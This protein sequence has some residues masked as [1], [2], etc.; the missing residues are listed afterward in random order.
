MKR[1]IIMLL[2]L[3][4]LI[5]LSAQKAS[6][7]RSDRKRMRQERDE[8][9]WKNL[10]EKFEVRIGWCGYPV[11]DESTL[12]YNQENIYGPRW[13]IPDGLEG[14]Y[15]IKKDN[16]YMTAPIFAEFSWHVKARFTLSG[17][18]YVNYLWGRM[19]D[20]TDQ[21]IHSKTRGASVTILP[22]ARFY[23][24]NYE[25]CR[26]YTSL[27]LGVNFAKYLE[28]AHVIPAFQFTPIGITVGRKVFGFGE[29]Y[30]IGTVCLGG[31]IGV[32]YRF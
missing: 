26:L 4:Q 3:L 11:A 19:I 1:T 7:Y 13:Y 28:N 8:L 22:E 25:K 27:G 31:K 16:T 24:A 14:L 10:D 15:C 9:F 5:P 6:D 20:P 23:W 32:G 18:V 30:T 2:A 29:C 12:L 21:T 17:G